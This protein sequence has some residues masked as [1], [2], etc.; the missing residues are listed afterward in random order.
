M[1]SQTPASHWVSVRAGAEGRVH[2]RS[3]A[4]AHRPGGADRGAGSAAAAAAAAWVLA[5]G[6]AEPHW[7]GLPA[8]PA[9]AAS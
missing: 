2:Q 6:F 1:T 7:P 4:G 9:A 8:A 5:R 3:L